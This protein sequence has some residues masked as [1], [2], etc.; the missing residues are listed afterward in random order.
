MAAAAGE[1]V[2]DVYSGPAEG[3]IPPF[4]ETRVDSE[5]RKFCRTFHPMAQ[6]M[7]GTQGMPGQGV[8]GQG[9][10]GQGGLRNEY[11][12]VWDRPLPE[13]ATQRSKYPQN[14]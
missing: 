12:H 1:P 10:P 6:G 7:P 13:P 3:H 2:Y 14:L 4:M 5:G 8:P 9:V 11:T